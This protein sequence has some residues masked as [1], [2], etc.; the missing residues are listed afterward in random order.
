MKLQKRILTSIVTASLLLTINISPIKAS[1][2]VEYLRVGLCY[3]S[4]AVTKYTLNSESGFSIGTES[5]REFVENMTIKDTTL[6]VSIDNNG[7]ITYGENTFNTNSAER[8]TIAP[9]D[10]NLIIGNDKKHRGALQFLNA[11]DG[12]MTVVN[13]ISV[14]DYVKGVVPREVSASWHEEALKAQAVCARNYSISNVGKHGSSGFDVCTSVHCQVYGGVSAE[15]SRT[16]KAV[17]DTAGEYLMYNGELAETLFFS[18]SGGHTGNSIY[19]WGSD[20]PYLSGVE[21]DFENPE[22]NSRYTWSVTLTADQIAQKL[23]ANGNSIGAVTGIIA[24]AD[25][26]TGQVYKLTINGTNGSKTYTNDNTRGCFG[27]DVLYS[28]FYTVTP[29]TTPTGS[30]INAISSEGKKLISD[31]F[32]LSGKNKKTTIQFPFIAKSSDSKTELTAQALAYRFDG[33]GWGHGL[34][35][36]QY[37]AKGMADQ[38]YTYDEILAYYY[39]GTNLK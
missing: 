29:I 31:Y 17:D 2:T 5:D 35:M 13:F 8:L 39:P 23:T 14:D 9:A 19:V 34:G 7:N 32:V 3:G 6:V 20:I 25:E 26:T 10:D 24:K 18:S 22:E 38:G 1:E 21:N 36:S 12:K 28:Q 33:R 4:T 27:S 30:G 15:D 37:G 16:N 11:G